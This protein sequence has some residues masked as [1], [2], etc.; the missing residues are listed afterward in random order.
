MKR[1]IS[2]GTE[3]E[4][5]VVEMQE[6]SIW[7]QTDSTRNDFVD[8]A[9]VFLGESAVCT[10]NDAGQS[11]SSTATP[12]LVRRSSRLARRRSLR[13]GSSEFPTLSVVSPVSARIK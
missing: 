9:C 1:L 10:K 13:Q 12:V 4:Q 7:K 2:S 11:N 5:R 6:F 8:S 3:G